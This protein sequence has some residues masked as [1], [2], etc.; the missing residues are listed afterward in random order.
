MAEYENKIRCG[1]SPRASLNLEKAAKANAILDNRSYIT[2]QDIKDVAFDILR[3]R[4]L[5][6]YE[7]EAENITQDMII[8]KILETVDVP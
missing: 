7:A 4:I 8:A 6:S 1:A 2:P 3:H 5:L